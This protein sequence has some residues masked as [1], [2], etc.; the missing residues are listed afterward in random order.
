MFDVNQELRCDILVG[1][2]L[3]GT[4]CTYAKSPHVQKA[5]GLENNGTIEK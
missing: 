3:R 5:E 1:S 4:A 2:G